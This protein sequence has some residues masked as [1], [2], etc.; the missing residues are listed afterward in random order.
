M[1][2]EAGGGYVATE[3]LL[4]RGH[5]RVGFLNNE[6]PIPATAGRLEGYRR[7][8]EAHHVPF[9]PEL[10][11]IA[12]SE[13]SGGYRCTLSLMER[14]ERPTALFCYNDR[15]AMG[16]YDAARKLGL[17]IPGDVAIVGFDNQEIIAAQL[18][19]GLS[20]MQLPHYEMGRWA[21]KYLLGE[22]GGV[23]LGQP[24]Q[25]TLSCPFIERSSA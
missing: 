17:E 11:R 9:D 13:A 12:E 16:A 4:K 23:A 19:P 7:A 20:T 18:H 8:L 6:D 15:M 22:I 21:V 10:V 3:Y 14:E 24:V 1:P 5:R 2:D 25:Q